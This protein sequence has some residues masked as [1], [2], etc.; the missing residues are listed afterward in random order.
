LSREADIRDPSSSS[1]LNVNKAAENR[2]KKA[3]TKKSWVKNNP[4]KNSLLY[5]E[6]DIGTH[7]A[8]ASPTYKDDRNQ[9]ARNQKSKIIK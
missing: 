4:R 8:A 5:R 1:V 6:T 2:K 3:N 7:L 9:V